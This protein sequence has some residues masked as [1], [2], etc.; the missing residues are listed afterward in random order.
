MKTLLIVCGTR[1][2]IIKLA[3]VYLYLKQ[4][5]WANVLWLHTGQHDEMSK[6]ILAC[7]GIAPDITLVREGTTLSEFSLGL[8]KQLDIV[9]EQTQS[10]MTIV[11]GD[12]ESAFVGALASFY[13]RIPVAHVEAGLRTYDLSRPFPEEGL[14]QMITRITALNFAPTQGAADALLQEG[15][16]PEFVYLTGN[17]VID[18]QKWIIDHHQ[19]HTKASNKKQI[20]VTMHR[21]EN[22]GNEIEQACKAIA[23]LASKYDELEFLFPVHLNPAVKDQVFPILGNL[24]NVHLTEPLDYLDMQQALANSWLTLT[25]SGG[26]QEEAPTFGLPVLVLRKETERP[27]A[28]NAGCAKIVGTHQSDIIHSVEFLLN[29]PKAYKDMQAKTNPFGDGKA[30]ERIAEVI[31]SHLQKG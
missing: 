19:I 10:A 28:V 26:I 6:K 20:L 9:L 23:H 18:A 12:T 27:E 1:P 4:Q 13:Q 2:E 11:Q 24:Q 30:S 8:R 22:W 16:P 3:P 25:D 29:T 7:F 17:T 15:I 14:R 31:H 5:S 21:R